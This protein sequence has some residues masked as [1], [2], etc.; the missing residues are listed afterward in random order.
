MALHLAHFSQH[1]MKDAEDHQSHVGFSQLK[2]L[3][4]SDDQFYAGCTLNGGAMGVERMA[5]PFDLSASELSVS[6]RLALS[7][8]GHDAWTQAGCLSFA[9]RCNFN[10]QVIENTVPIIQEINFH[11]RENIYTIG[12]EDNDIYFIEKGKI[13]IYLLNTMNNNKIPIKILSHGESFGER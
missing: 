4:G 10:D 2:I 12:Q 13:E 6:D 8:Y 9:L 5:M 1:M 11:P 7:G 3:S